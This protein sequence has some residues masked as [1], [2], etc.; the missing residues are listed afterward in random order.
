MHILFTGICGFSGSALAEALLDSFPVGEL[1]ITGLDNLSRMGSWLNWERHKRRGNRLR[2][3]GIR[4]ASDLERLG[5]V[6]WAIDVAANRSV[7]AGVDG[8]NS[9]CQL[10]EHN[11]FGTIN[12]LEFCKRLGAGFLL[13]STSRVYSI[14]PLT[15]LKMSLNGKRFS[16]AVDQQWPCGMSVNGVTENGPAYPPASRTGDSKNNRP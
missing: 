13:L 8:K 1:T 16:P 5:P 10:L 4:Q 15:N 9:S 14:E 2:H 3:A 6:N 11:L 12:L 7:L